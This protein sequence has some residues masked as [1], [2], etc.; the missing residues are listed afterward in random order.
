MYSKKGDEGEHYL[1]SKGRNRQADFSAVVV[2]DGEQR[3]T[4]TARNCNDVRCD[5]LSHHPIPRY[6]VL[7]LLSSWLNVPGWLS[8]PRQL[9]GAIDLLDATYAGPDLVTDCS[10][11]YIQGPEAAAA[12]PNDDD[13]SMVRAP[14]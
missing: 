14:R 7:L 11:V 8:R 12:R 3:R 13:A 4:P 5:D 1:L 10:K 2:I 6:F 9:L